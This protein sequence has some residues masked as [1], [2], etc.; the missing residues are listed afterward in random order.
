MF[1]VSNRRCKICTPTIIMRAGHDVC[2][3]RHWSEGGLRE[4]DRGSEE[5]RGTYIWLQPHPCILGNNSLP[6]LPRRQDQEWKKKWPLLSFRWLTHSPLWA[7][8]STHAAVKTARGKV[9]SQSGRKLLSNVNV[10]LR[11]CGQPGHERCWATKSCLMLCVVL[12]PAA[13]STACCWCETQG[14]CPHSCWCQHV[15]HQTPTSCCLTIALVVLLHDIS[16][17]ICLFFFFSQ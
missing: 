14:K 9:R 3:I 13:G 15:Q 2:H 16:K 11:P 4:G 5:W 17:R 10:P 7:D 6:S 8:W 1:P 12:L